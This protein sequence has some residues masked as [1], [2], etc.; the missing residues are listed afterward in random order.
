MDEVT[1]DCHCL[2]PIRQ[3]SPLF[4]VKFK[5]EICGKASM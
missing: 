5:L 3:L 1:I 2:T 4:A